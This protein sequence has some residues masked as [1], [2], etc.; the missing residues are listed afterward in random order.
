MT[1]RELAVE[2]GVAS[3]CLEDELDM[4]EKHSLISK[5]PK[6][7]YPTNLIIFTDDLTSALYERMFEFACRLMNSHTSKNVGTQIETSHSTNLQTNSKGRGLPPSFVFHPNN[8]AL[9]S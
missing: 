8:N 5:F 1:A 3:V 6:G 2:L 7:R 4:L 9:K